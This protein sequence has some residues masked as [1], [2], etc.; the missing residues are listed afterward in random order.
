MNA[1][2]TAMAKNVLIGYQFLLIK[3]QQ[4]LDKTDEL[5]DDDVLAIREISDLFNQLLNNFNLDDFY[6]FRKQLA[7]ADG[8]LSVYYNKKVTDI[9]PIIHSIYEI[10][11]DNPPNKFTLAI[12][13]FFGVG[14]N[15]FEGDS[16][17]GKTFNKDESINPLA[18]EANLVHEELTNLLAGYDV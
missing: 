14:E 4:L 8:K 7:F 9:Y 12:K 18:I 17:L 6:S 2:H 3:V 1:T 5:Y 13:D 10:Q 16:V 11:K 15:L